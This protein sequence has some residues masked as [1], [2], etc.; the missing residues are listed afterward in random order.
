[1]AYILIYTTFNM[2]FTIFNGISLECI[3]GVHQM[4]RQFS[5]FPTFLHLDEWWVPN[6]YF[7]S[8]ES[9]TWTLICAINKSSN[10]TWE[11]DMRHQNLVCGTPKIFK[12]VACRENWHIEIFVDNLGGWSLS[13]LFTVLTLIWVF[14]LFIK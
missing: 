10:P 6:R 7:H 13:D 11:K 1:M 5:T 14:I 9:S 8:F 12:M 3:R 4:M 2:M